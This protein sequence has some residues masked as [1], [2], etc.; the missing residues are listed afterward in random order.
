MIQLAHAKT[1]HVAD[2]PEREQAQKHKCK[3]NREVEF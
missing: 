1:G 2:V 3:I